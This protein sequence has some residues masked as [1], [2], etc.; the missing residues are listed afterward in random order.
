LQNALPYLNVKADYNEEELEL[1]NVGSVIL[2]NFLAMS[3]VD[4]RKDIGD[5]ELNVEIR[6][7][8]DIVVNQFPLPGEEVNK[9]STVIL[10]VTREDEERL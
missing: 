10:F 4:V 9:G 8:G 3:V 5:L 2:P 1:P 7:L 6:G